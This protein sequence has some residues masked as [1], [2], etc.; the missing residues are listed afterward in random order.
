[1]QA[2]NKTGSTIPLSFD[3][4]PFASTDGFFCFEMRNIMEKGGGREG[5]EEWE[6]NQ[7]ESE[8]LN[9]LNVTKIKEMKF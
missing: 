6:A 7:E 8:R 1:M 9:E 3:S 4:T 5:G 2:D